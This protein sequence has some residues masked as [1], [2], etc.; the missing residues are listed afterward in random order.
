MASRGVR[1]GILIVT[2]I[3]AL[4]VLAEAM[5]QLMRLSER[6]LFPPCY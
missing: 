4:I 3:T 5:A 2:V 1:Y 6:C